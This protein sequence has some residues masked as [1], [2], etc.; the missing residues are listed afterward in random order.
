MLNN[1][2]G[3]YQIIVSRF[4]IATIIL[5]VNTAFVG[6][7]LQP[8]CFVIAAIYLLTIIYSLLLLARIQNVFF[9]YLQIIF[10]LILETLLIHFTG[11]INSIL[12]ILYPLSSISA[13]L[14]VSP[15]AGVVVAL[16]G[17]ALYS[18]LVTLEHFKIIP[19]LYSPETAPFGS[20][21]LFSLLYFRV[22]V[23][24]LIGFLSAYISGQV[25]SKE[26][27]VLS[28]EEKLKRED[29]LSV[30]GKLAAATAHEIRNPL[31]SILGCVETLKTSL[32]LDDR[33]KKLFNL[34]IKETSRLNN[35][36]NGLLEYVKPRKLCFRKVDFAELIDE[37]VLLLENSKDFKPGIMIQK[38]IEVKDL[39]VD[40][41]PE[42]M[43]QVLFNLLINAVTAVAK[44][45]K[46]VI[47]SRIMQ[48]EN[49]LE[50]EITDNG[51]GIGK[52]QLKNMFEPFSSGTEKGVGLGL[53]IAYNIIKE[54]NGTISVQSVKGKGTTFKIFL[55]L[56]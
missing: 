41:D 47:N 21:Q 29:R 35:I 12:S 6:L 16:W 42:Q 33:H 11:G 46:I 52:D 27:L 28:L 7:G 17:S 19:M 48:A 32:Q 24:C 25:K 14:F 34:V 39:K 4:V 51:C 55:P 45:G 36:I 54:H 3:L 5:I 53:A 49:Q 13:A 1:R 20:T 40:C 43:R 44:M 37:V 23:F 56:K 8:T 31:A 15:R 22:I 10:D 18:G 9:L 30:L 50:V 38:K 26:R 2:S